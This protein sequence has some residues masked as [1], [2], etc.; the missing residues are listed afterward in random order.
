M[1]TYRHFVR[2]DHRQSNVYVFKPF[3]VYPEQTKDH[4]IMLYDLTAA[5]HCNYPIWT[6]HFRTSV[7]NSQKALNRLICGSEHLNI[8]LLSDLSRLW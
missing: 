1:T 5:F 3:L 2:N 6:C 8:C 7:S 4:F